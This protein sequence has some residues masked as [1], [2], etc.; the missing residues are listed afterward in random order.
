MKQL[1]QRKRE[2]QNQHRKK[3]RV[4]WDDDTPLM[5]LVNLQQIDVFKVMLK[6]WEKH[7]T[8]P[9]HPSKTHH[10]YFDSSY[11]LRPVYAAI[12]A[13]LSV[14]DY[15]LKVRLMEFYRYLASHSNLGTEQNIKVQLYRMRKLI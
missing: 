9:I 2:L 14:T 13:F 11:S 6:D 1:S 15:P 12:V 10:F 4:L 7:T 3:R 5:R 8:H